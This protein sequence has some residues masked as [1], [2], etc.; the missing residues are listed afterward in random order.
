MLVET[1][2]SEERG[3]IVNAVGE[4]MKGILKPADYGELPKSGWK[5]WCNRA[6]W[7]ATCGNLNRVSSR[8]TPR[9]EFGKSRT[10][11]AS[12]SMT[13]LLIPTA[14]IFGIDADESR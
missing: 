1:G 12:G 4:K 13:L 2:G 11:V 7:Q 9:G 6:A 8:T 10:P 5:R 14:Q 3:K